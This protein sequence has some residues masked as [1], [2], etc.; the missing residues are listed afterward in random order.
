M[1]YNISRDPEAGREFLMR[2]A[3]RITFGTDLFSSATREQAIARAGITFRWLESE[4]QFRVP[5]SADFLLGPPADGVIRGMRLPDDVLA[6]IYRGNLMRL[7]GAAP[8]ALDVREAA[9][10]CEDIARIAAGMSA[11]VEEETQAG[12]VAAALQGA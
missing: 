7:V 4:D 12:K 6:R 10:Y 5:E 3:D 1:L 11:K 9:A 8:Q 2:Y